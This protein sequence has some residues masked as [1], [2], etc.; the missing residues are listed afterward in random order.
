VSKIPKSY[1]ITRITDQVPLVGDPKAGP[2]KKAKTLKIDQFPWY[3]S[4]DKQATTVR[5]VYDDQAMYTQFLCEDEHIFAQTTQLNGPVC[6]DSC[7]E[8]F[9]SILPEEA[10][11]YFNLEINCCGTFLLGFNSN[12][13]GS[14]VIT[15]Q[16]AGRIKVASSLPGPTKAESPADNGWWVA[17]RL[18]FD[19]IAELP[20]QPVKV[21]SGTAWKANFYRCGGKTD[22][23]YGCWSPADSSKFAKP[24]FHVPECFGTFIFE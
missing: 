8:F 2:W 12:R 15:P 10:P 16:L 18:P 4:G 22:R 7:V 23:Q 5:V 1:V 11:D 19:V 24:A 6:K 14:G 3:T 20:G 9:A 13:R 17:V 21:S